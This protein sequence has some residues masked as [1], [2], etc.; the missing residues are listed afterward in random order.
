MAELLYYQ[1]DFSL[2]GAANGCP[3][4]GALWGE[5]REGCEPGIY[6]IPG[7][8]GSPTHLRLL[9]RWDHEAYARNSLAVPE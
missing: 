9:R 8:A 2:T 3:P 7:N 6:S 4:Q 1:R 5:C